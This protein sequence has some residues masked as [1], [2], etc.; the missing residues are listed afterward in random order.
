MPL[1]CNVDFCT[2]LS[3]DTQERSGR[4]TESACREQP[5]GPK[6][7]ATPPLPAQNL[8]TQYDESGAEL[9]S[10]LVGKCLL[11]ARCRSA[12]ERVQQASSICMHVLYQ[13]GMRL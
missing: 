7:H 9:V 1:H 5:T 12:C 3:E 8:R 11:P 4:L 6:A 2:S 10:V 13:A